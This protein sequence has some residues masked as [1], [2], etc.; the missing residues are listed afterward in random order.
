MKT[1]AAPALELSAGPPRIAVLPSEERATERPCFAFPTA[2]IP[3]SLAPCCD[4][5]PALRVNTHAAPA[6][7]L[8]EDPPT[9]A[10]L[11]S[12]ERATEAPC[13]A[14]PTAPVPTSLGPCC[15]ET[16]PPRVTCD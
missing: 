13:C 5:T 6:F 15:V 7:V 10:V 3:T 2:P 8:S 9:I 4:Q 12:E 1:H 14:P 16:A 11:P